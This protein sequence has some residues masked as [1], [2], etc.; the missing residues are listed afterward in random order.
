MKKLRFLIILVLVIITSGCS[1]KTGVDVIIIGKDNITLKKGDYLTYDYWNGKYIEF[2][3]KEYDDDPIFYKDIKI[4]DSISDVITKMDIKSGYAIINAEVPT[5][6]H[7]G[8]TDVIEFVYKDINSFD[9]DYLDA[10]I[11]VVFEKDGSNWKMID[12][13]TSNKVLYGEI[14]GDYIMYGIDI[15]GF[16]DEEYVEQYKVISINVKY[17]DENEE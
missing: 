15:N 13:K 11:I 6:E 17:I 12:A 7:D 9:F 10:V 3:D 2:N 8:T 1:N 16:D 5:E 14:T 4:G